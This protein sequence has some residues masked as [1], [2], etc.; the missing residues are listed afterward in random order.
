M[1]LLSTT[2][3]VSVSTLHNEDLSNN[4]DLF[5]DNADI[6]DGNLQNNE[7]KLLLDSPDIVS[8]SENASKIADI[9]SRHDNE[10]LYNMTPVDIVSGLNNGDKTNIDIVQEIQQCR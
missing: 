3:E 4:A 9:V 7:D 1:H 8:G 10:D 5:G 2:S 6:S